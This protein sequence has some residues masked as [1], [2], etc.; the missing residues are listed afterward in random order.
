[1]KGLGV[2][3]VAVLVMGGMPGAMG[4]EGEISGAGEAG[5]FLEKI[6]DDL[7]ERGA[8]GV[9]RTAAGLAALE[10][11]RP[12]AAD[13]TSTVPSS[14]PRTLA[15][16]V[17]DLISAVRLAGEEFRVA[18][19]VSPQ[20]ARDAI[21]AAPAL[22]PSD[23]A[24]GAEPPSELQRLA[25]RFEGQIDR[26]RMIA[27]ALGLAEAIERAL[28]QLRSASLRPARSGDAACD[29]LDEPP[30]ICIGSDGAN[31]YDEPAAIQIDLGG[32]D[33]YLNHPGS[34]NLVPPVAISIDVAGNDHYLSAREASGSLPS[35]QGSA[36]LG[37]GLLTDVAGDDRYTVT[38]SPTVQGVDTLLVGQGYGVFGVGVV[39]DREGNDVYEARV[40]GQLSNA[41]FQ[42]QGY[43][44]FGGVGALV[45][46]GGNDLYEAVARPTARLDHEGRLVSGNAKAEG[47]GY[48]LLGGTGILAD[49][50]GNDT[51]LLEAGTAEM[52]PGTPAQAPAATATVTGGGY[53]NTSASG[54]AT[55]GPGSTDW[56]VRAQASGAASGTARIDALAVGAF[57]GTGAIRDSG[58]DDVYRAEAS[59]TAVVIDDS[60]ACACSPS[61]VATAGPT[62][63]TAIG[64][65]FGGGL[66]IVQELGGNDRYEVVSRSFARAESHDRRIDPKGGFAAATAGDAFAGGEGA[67]DIGG[68]GVLEDLV[69]DD[70]YIGVA[71]SRAEAESTPSGAGD[72]EAKS[73]GARTGLQA[74]GSVGGAALL[75]DLG[76]GD[77][78]SS[79]S[80][81]VAQAPEGIED[82]GP[83]QTSAQG[84][85]SSGLAVPPLPDLPASALVIDL[86]SG[87]DVF[88]ATPPDPACVGTRGGQSWLDCSTGAAGGTNP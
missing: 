70:R 19:R 71:E 63:T 13:V 54:L 14:V 77:T 66:G 38:D 27:A 87:T 23:L 41:N 67:G 2:I 32:D 84:S 83:A 72:A 48:G 82:P 18:V 3:A 15:E 17:G 26:S 76:G 34:A 33:L 68:V 81:S 49:A 5:R 7:A 88:L 61:A 10:M 35:V 31:T 46:G 25:D 43:G 75:R 39:D 8:V 29:V 57:G 78:Y 40:Q 47:Q 36:L 24:F 22:P 65:G 64:G 4:T 21:A 55:W 6:P 56:T 62:Q 11:P 60:D 20:E 28:P 69:G 85:L 12:A 16:P 53:G 44:S 79:T 37:I 45:D 42:V 51:A 52:A 50:F 9:L 73:T 59:S 58:G 80:T 86:G 74:N 30:A 1:M